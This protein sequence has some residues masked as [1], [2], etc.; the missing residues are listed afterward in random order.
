[1]FLNAQWWLI[2]NLCPKDIWDA[3]VDYSDVILFCHFLKRINST[4]GAINI[5]TEIFFTS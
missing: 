3:Q 1:M 4:D 2:I 5:T